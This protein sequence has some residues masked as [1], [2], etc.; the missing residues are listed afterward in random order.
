MLRLSTFWR[1]LPLSKSHCNF[2]SLPYRPLSSRGT[3]RWAHTTTQLK[4]D[5]ISPS[6]I[7]NMGQPA[8][9]FGNYDLI[10]RVK[11]DFTDVVIS[12]WKSRVTGLTVIHLDYEGLLCSGGL[13]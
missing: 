1:R 5:A 13:C 12:K 6:P 2:R 10:K 4:Q 11:L 3:F 8:E 9:S 7:V